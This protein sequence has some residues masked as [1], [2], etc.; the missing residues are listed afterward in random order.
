MGVSVFVW[1]T[2]RVILYLEEDDS[3]KSCT[4]NTITEKISTH[5]PSIV[6]PSGGAT[7]V[8]TMGVVQ[9]CG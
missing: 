8:D 2:S 6:P 7:C 4:M 5:M 1:E 3:K 9:L